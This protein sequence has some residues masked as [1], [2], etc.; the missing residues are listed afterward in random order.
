MNFEQHIKQWVT[1]DDQLKLLS[2][3]VKT[4]RE[5][6][7]QLSQQINTQVADKHLTNTT[8]KISDGNLKFVSV[9]DTQPLT[10]K[11]LEVC[12]GE[13]IKNEEQVKKIVQYVK[14]KRDFNYVPEIK[15][16]YNN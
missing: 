4:L 8:V 3:K 2:D 1:V 13:I 5:Q 7:H 11:H 14:S 16:T 15:R 6:K 10:F 9:K 12:L